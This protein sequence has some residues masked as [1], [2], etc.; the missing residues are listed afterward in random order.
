MWL[1]DLQIAID[2]LDAVAAHINST[3]TDTSKCKFVYIFSFSAKSTRVACTQIYSSHFQ[4]LT[5]HQLLLNYL[6]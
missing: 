1:D 5:L 2:N 4:N 6:E 3:D